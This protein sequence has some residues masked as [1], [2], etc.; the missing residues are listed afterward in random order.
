V[1]ASGRRAPKRWRPVATDRN[2]FARELFEGL[3]G[4]YDLLAELLSF[5]QNARWRRRLVQQMPARPEARVLDVATG[6]G[7]VAIALAQAYGCRVVGVDL[8]PEML[9]MGR[10]RVTEAGLAD[11]ITLQ[12]ARAEALPFPTA[13]FDGLTFT[14]LLRYVEDPA[15][16]LN[17]LARV[18]KPGGRMAGMEF[19]VPPAPWW[20][21]GWRLYTRGVLPAVGWL[22]S[23]SWLAVG[24]FLGPSIEAHYREY[25]LHRLVELWQAAGLTGVRTQAMSLGSGIVTW[26]VKGHGRGAPGDPA[27]GVLRAA[28]G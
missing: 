26:G 20:R 25:P 22:V 8:S 14:Y 17:E 11:R 2:R 27:A 24:R 9:A 1:P 15:T 3:A 18:L 7:G 6:T 10:R 16:T 4:R 23:E 28:R 21:M 12:E 13:S 19:G 5:G